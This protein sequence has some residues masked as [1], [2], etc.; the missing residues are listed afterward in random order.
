MVLPLGEKMEDGHERL[1]SQAGIGLEEK[2]GKMIVADVG[3]GSPA[4]KAKIDFDWE[5]KIIELP[6]DRLPKEIF[7][8]PAMALL[9]LII[10]VQRRR[11]KGPGEA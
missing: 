4:E 9:G 3:F 8:I 2:D 10:V 6:T 5:V 7:W 11:G 1:L